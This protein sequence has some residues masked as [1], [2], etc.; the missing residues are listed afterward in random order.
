MDTY[1]IVAPIKNS[2]KGNL[3]NSD[4]NDAKILLC[5][6]FVTCV[7]EKKNSHDF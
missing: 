2:A 4:F 7:S 6:E 1:Y 3:D 5:L